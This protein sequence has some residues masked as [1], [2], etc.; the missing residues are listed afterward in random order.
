VG[1]AQRERKRGRGAT[2]LREQGSGACSLLPVRRCLHGRHPS[3]LFPWPSSQFS[4]EANPM[5][6]QPEEASIPE[7]VDRGPP[8]TPCGV[9]YRRLSV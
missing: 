6:P 5:E 8:F 2:S 4:H 1:K 9:L 7:P 3:P